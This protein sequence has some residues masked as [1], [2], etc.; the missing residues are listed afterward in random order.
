MVTTRC[1]LLLIAIGFAFCATAVWGQL[2]DRVPIVGLLALSAGPNDTIYEAVREGLRERGYVEGRD[3]SF[4]YRGAQG[5][6][7]R[8][9]ELAKELVQAKVDVIVTGVEAAAQA[10]K[11][12]TQTIPIVAVTYDTDP[13]AAELIESYNRPHGNITGIYTRG[14]DQIAKEL[15]LIKEVLPSASRIGL[16]WDD[17]SPA[18]RD[19]IMSAARALGITIEVI[20]LEAP[21]DVNAAFRALKQAKL[22]VVM[23]SGGPPLYVQRSRIGALALENQ[24]AAIGSLRDVTE[25]G[26]LLSYGGNIRDTFRR[27]AYYIDRLLKGAKPSE[28]PVEQSDRFWL[29]VNL[30]AAKALGITIPKSVLLR[31]DEVIR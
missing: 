12:A 18:Q 19:S 5:H 13:V 3:F 20:A 7:E 22:R 4:Q 16:L 11:H 29:T 9:P 8:L 27:V 17:T 26:G 21:Y 23:V 24:V 31:A 1:V 10:A 2:P 28:L 30:K 6:V 15:E 14:S 25:A